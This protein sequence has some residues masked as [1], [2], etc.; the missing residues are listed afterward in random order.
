MLKRNRLI[1]GFIQFA[2]RYFGW[3]GWA[4]LTYNSVIENVFL[5][6]YIALQKKLSGKWFLFYFFTFFL[7]SAASTTY[8]YLVNDFADK[9][10]D[11]FHGKDNTFVSDSKTKAAF[12]VLLS[13]FL[14]IVFGMFFVRENFFLGLWIC[15]ALVATFY[16]LKPIRLKE[17][18]K[19]GL[20]CVVIAQ[21]V[22]PTL[23]I[24][25]AF[26]YFRPPDVI[27]FTIYIFFRGLSSDLNHQLEDYEKDADTGTGTYTVQAGF[28]K[29]RKFFRFSLEAE[30][31]LLFICLI[32]MCVQ[33]GSLKSNPASFLFPLF[34]VYVVLYGLSWWQIVRHKGNVDVNPYV[35]GSR[36]VFHFIHHTFPSVLLPLYLLVLLALRDWTFAVPLLFLAVYRKLYSI[37]LIQ[38]SLSSLRIQPKT[39]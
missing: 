27:L 3:R 39:P 37:E 13:L 23:L 8:G 6:F 30:K 20:F 16:S 26:Q 15:W 29:A 4:V 9:E 11:L 10:L 17:K 21:R 1:S 2:N 38:K 5:F 22:L 35:R 14:S 19:I 31:A 36:N 12:V 32:N 25:A 7:F 28:Q 24:F 18:G 34:A 33:T